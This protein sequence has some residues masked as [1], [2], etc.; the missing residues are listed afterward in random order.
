MGDDPIYFFLFEDRGQQIPHTAVD[1]AKKQ[2]IQKTYGKQFSHSGCPKYDLQIQ[3]HCA[4]AK[5]HKQRT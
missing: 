3:N 4:V 1:Q 2:D 5:N